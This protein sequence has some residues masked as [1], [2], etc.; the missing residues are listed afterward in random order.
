MNTTEELLQQRTSTLE[1]V[2]LDSAMANIKGEPEAGAAVCIFWDKS[3][4]DDI[5]EIDTG[6]LFQTPECD[7]NHEY[8]FFVHVP[9]PEN[10]SGIDTPPAAFVHL[11]ALA[12]FSI[13]RIE[14]IKK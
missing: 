13:K 5:P 2:D 6:Y 12:T 11:L 9:R 4:E 7:P 10:N 8:D 14:V 1:T 3:C